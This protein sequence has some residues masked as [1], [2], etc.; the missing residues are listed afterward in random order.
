MSQLNVLPRDDRKA[1]Y[2]RSNCVG[3]RQAMTTRPETPPPTS[4]P[5]QSTPATPVP[6]Q[7]TQTIQ[8]T[9]P[10]AD[11][12]ASLTPSKPDKNFAVYVIF[13]GTRAG[14]FTNWPITKRLRDSY[15]SK[16]DPSLKP[17]YKGYESVW[18]ACVIF[19][20]CFMYGL[21]GEEGERLPAIVWPE[22]QIGCSMDAFVVPQLREGIKGDNV[23]D[24]VDFLSV[25]PILLVDAAYTKLEA[26]I[27]SYSDVSEG[28][29]FVVVRGRNPGVYENR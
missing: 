4:R 27:S 16:R 26:I 13:R 14:V 17:I 2:A 10:A 20:L 7:L 15:K 19:K 1:K 28:E 29:F 9:T 21:V 8:V 23:M 5:A 18:E 3:G 6:T 11:G 24:P 25:L 22:K 12:T